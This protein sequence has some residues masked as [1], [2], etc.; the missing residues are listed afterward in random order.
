MF[1]W[2]FSCARVIQTL[3]YNVVYL[4]IKLKTQKRKLA[5]NT[6][7]KMMESEH[8][9]QKKAPL[10]I[11]NWGKIKKGKKLFASKHHQSW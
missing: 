10:Q 6:L 7:T 1:L 9:E 8:S 11:K 5:K 2:N 4:Q 3:R